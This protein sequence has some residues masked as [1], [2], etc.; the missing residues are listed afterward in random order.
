MSSAYSTRRVRRHDELVALLELH[1]P[2]SSHALGEVL[3][4]GLPSRSCRAWI[5]EDTERH[6]AAAVVLV[7]PTFDRWHAMVLLLDQRAAADVAAIVDR[8]PAWSVTGVATDIAPVVPLLRRRSFVDVRPWVVTAYPNDV[9]DVADDSTRLANPSDLDALVEL[10]STFEFVAGLTAW[11]LR[12]MLRH[13]LDRH[14]IIVVEQPG[15]EGVLVGALAVMTRTRRYGTLGLLTVVPEHRGAGWSWAL[16]ARAQAIGNALGLAG[17]AALAG[18]NPMDLED[19]LGDDAYVAV[20]LV[21]PRRF[22]GQGRLR[23]LY[24]RVQPL[25]P[26][27]PIWFREPGEPTRIGD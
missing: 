27:E 16:V 22:R 10:Y 1:E 11:Q 25:H 26:R 7:R 13:M 24:G 8:S 9:T 12:S 21:A 19:H 18:S 14:Y 15:G 23:D 5:V 6:P 17:I 4:R 3:D 20:H 2:R